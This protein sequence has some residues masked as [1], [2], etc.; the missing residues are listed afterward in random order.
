MPDHSH[1]NIPEELKQASANKEFSTNTSDNL[2]AAANGSEVSS[3][4]SQT[5]DTTAAA[6][7]RSNDRRCS[8]DYTTYSTTLRPQGLPPPSPIRPGGPSR[9]GSLD[10]LEV[11]GSCMSQTAPLSGTAA[12]TAMLNGVGSPNMLQQHGGSNESMA[13]ANWL[14]QQQLQQSGLLDSSY[15]S[16]PVTPAA[17]ARRAAS[18]EMAAAAPG[19]LSFDTAAHTSSSSRRSLDTARLPGPMT[20]AASGGLWPTSS[21]FSSSMAT[22]PQVPEPRSPQTAARQAQQRVLLQKQQLQLL[23]SYQQEQPDAAAYEQQLQLMLALQRQAASAAGSRRASSVEYAMSG[24]GSRRSSLDYAAGGSRRG[25]FADYMASA[26][27][28]GRRG[29]YM[30]YM[31]GT[32]SPPLISP[33]TSSLM[34]SSLMTSCGVSED[35]QSSMTS[36]M[37]SFPATVPSLTLPQL[38]HALPVPPEYGQLSNAPLEVP[39]RSSM[40]A[41]YALA[42]GAPANLLLAASSEAAAAQQQAAATRAELELLSRC[43]PLM[44]G[45]AAGS[46]LVGS[47]YYNLA[48]YTAAA[49]G[50]VS[51]QQQGGIGPKLNLET[52]AELVECV[53]RGELGDSSAPVMSGVISMLMQQLQQQQLAA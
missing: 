1:L 34:T 9:P 33:G 2:N 51:Q 11:P 45:G 50:G 29:S 18:L 20:P 3:L 52:V 12:M 23:Q 44:P 17:A 16:A 10:L 47:G 26:A 8:S 31:Y 49:Q 25:S 38:S 19:R 28:A 32:A 36:L 30:E 24:T 27:A 21:L 13:A 4:A 15:Y 42:A 41:G 6:T 7:R 46:G 53:N 14:L 40:D 39:Q 22:D 35:Y 48:Q 43:A 37:A 5:A